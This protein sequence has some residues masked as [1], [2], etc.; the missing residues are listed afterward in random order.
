MLRL[1]ADKELLRLLGIKYDEAKKTGLLLA[2]AVAGIGIAGHAFAVNSRQ[3][4]A[5]DA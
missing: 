5:D 4:Q 1:K 2:A 3:I